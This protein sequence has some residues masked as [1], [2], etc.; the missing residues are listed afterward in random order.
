MS[1]N[2]FRFA[3]TPG[4]GSPSPGRSRA[5]MAF[6]IPQLLVYTAASGVLLAA[7]TT[8]LIAN[9]RTNSNME[10]YQ[11]AEERW[12][13]ISSLIQLEASEADEVRYGEDVVCGGV[14]NYNE[15]Q[16]SLFTLRVPLLDNDPTK[17]T[18]TRIHYYK[19]GSGPEA[20]L[21]RCG[22]PYLPNGKLRTD[23]GYVDAVVGMKTNIEIDPNLRSPESF[24][25]R[26]DLYTAG[27]KKVFS[28]SSTATAGVEPV[29]PGSP[30]P[31]CP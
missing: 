7:T 18:F 13:R 5:A 9:I 10:L 19:S 27:N 21:S 17:V 3:S 30:P 2:P 25:F 16:K 1:S 12:S 28:R 15:E 6:T 4:P 29:C 31:V 22:F 11:R 14:G 8:T 26:I 24:T 23:E 20:T